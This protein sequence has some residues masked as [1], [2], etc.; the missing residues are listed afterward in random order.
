M[1]MKK[2]W[3]EILIV[4]GTVLLFLALSYGF[5]PEVLSGKIV[6]QG[7]ISS[8][9]GMTKEI[10]DHNAAMPEDE[11]LWTNSMFGGMPVVTMWDDFDGDATNPIYKFLLLGKRP[12]TYFF[13]A[14]LGGFLLMLAMGIKWILAI[15][16]AIAIAFCSYNMQI[17]QVGH[18]TKM[19]AI[20]FAPWVLAAMIFTYRSAME[21]YRKRSWKSWLPKTLLGAT[22]FGLALSF[23]VKANHPQITYYLA[24][25]IFVYVIALFIS[26][27]VADKKTDEDKVDK[28][29]LLKGKMVRF[30]S[31]S[32]LLLVIGC[33]GIATNVNK[34]LPTYEYS[35]AT[36]R[37]GSELSAAKG[38]TQEKG[39][40]LEYATAWSYGPNEMANLMIPNWNGG[41]SSGALSTDSE[42][43][44]LL[45]RAGQPNLNQVIKNMPLYWGPQPFTAGPMYLGAIC[46]FLFILG[47]FLFKGKEKWWLLV[48]TILAIF[49]AWGSHMMWFTK[50]W[51]D[52]V[53]M[54][55]KFRTVS[56]ALTI[57]QITVPLLGFLVLD[58]I[59]KG[60]YRG[61]TVRKANI[62]AFALT[63]GFCLLAAIFPGIAGDFISSADAGQP[64]VLVDALVAD[65]KALLVNDALISFG[66]IAAVALMI[67]WAFKTKSPFANTGRLYFV[68]GAVSLLVLLDLGSVGKRYLNKSHFINQKNFTSQFAER[69]VDKI[70]H[71]D[72]SDFR[73]LDLSVNTFNDAHQ[74]YQH[75]CIGGYSPA[76]MQRYQDLIERYISKEINSVYSATRGVNTVS[77]L[78]NQLPELPVTSMLNGKYIIL[79]EE[80]APV[81]NSQT[82]GNVWFVD[83]AIAAASPDDEINLI[84]SADLEHEAIIGEDFAWARTSFD[85]AAAEMVS[86]DVIRLVAYAPNELR[87]DF[88]TSSERPAIFSEVYYKNGWKAWYEPA[89]S[90]AGEVKKGHYIPSTDAIELPLFRANWIL[91]G[92]VIPE[93]EGQIVMRFE[94]QSYTTGEKVSRASSILLLILLALAA[95]GRIFITD[96]MSLKF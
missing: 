27:F 10:A 12:A 30:F 13:V 6:N 65:R 11:T 28:N 81:R 20:A 91:R 7:D 63:G 93:G 41:A 21:A 9:K 40:D 2:I 4:V 77:E 55:N 25:I 43:Y 45:R 39:L 70:I 75:K 69:P 14:M 56:M 78:E 47:L 44:Q 60:E 90:K 52:Y 68:C 50:L 15:G 8:W 26:L 79:G 23:Q 76:K 62:M 3:K 17:I 86:D 5:V 96:K 38:S 71:Q 66:L 88:K 1:K 57:L 22:L 83:R 74:C 94:P 19:Q 16:G 58:R 49:L 59:L 24:I 72:K 95:G 29:T 61:K 82:L 64:D 46:V 35:K 37:G 89:G 54:Y 51:F 48:T 67:L 53:P 33:V 85:P 42:T 34:L 80:F 73:V 84:G 36:M 18:N 92:A 31:A 87:Y 32:A